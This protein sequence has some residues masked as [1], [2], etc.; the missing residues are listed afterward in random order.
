SG[1]A[2]GGETIYFTVTGANTLT[3]H[4]V[5]NNAGQATL[6]YT[7]A[8]TGSD[9]VSAFA[10]MNGNGVQGIGEPAAT[11]TITWTGTLPP[12]PA[13]FAPAQPTTAKVGC[14]YFA[15]TGHNLCA[16]FL[17]YW[18]QFGGLATYGYPLTEEFPENG[19]TV[20]YFERARFEWHPGTN[21]SRYDVLLGLVGD[22]VTAG[23][24]M[25]APFQ[26][27]SARAGCT[28]FAATGHNLCA[29]FG[30]F[31]MTFG[32]LATYGMPISEEFVER[33]PDTGQLYTVQYFER[34]RLE[35]HPG[36]WPARYDVMLGRLGAQVLALRYHTTY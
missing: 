29:G 31:W 18:T 4:M 20:Q 16:G 22:E 24:G 19:V 2:G 17:A 36:E 26:A 10:D 5:T 25:Q 32:G 27:T 1:L 13:P 7:G 12:A 34:A 33:N 15:A 30:A 3:Q 21:P 9:T 14:T 8:M 23:R 6:T 35:W 11:A 28:Y